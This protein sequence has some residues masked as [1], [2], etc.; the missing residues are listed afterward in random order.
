MKKL[1]VTRNFFS[2]FRWK[3]L[4]G[5]M[6]LVTIPGLV[7]G[8]FAYDVFK[9]ENFRKVE[10]SMQ[11]IAKD[12]REISRVYLQQ[13]NRVLKREEFLVEKRL[14]ALVDF[15]RD[16][17]FR[18]STS[19]TKQEVISSF[20]RWEKDQHL[21]RSGHLMLLDSAGRILVSNRAA[22][23]N[24]SFYDHLAKD[25]QAS[26]QSFLTKNLK[27]RDRD[28]VILHFRISEN[29]NQDVPVLGAFLYLPQVDLVLC[30]YSLYAD[31]KSYELKN[32]LQDE[33]KYK[34]GE[35]RISENGYIFVI[36]S[37]GDYVVSKGR[38]RDGENLLETRDLR[39][40]FLIKEIIERARSLEGDETF[41]MS[42]PWQNFGEKNTS[43]KIIVASYFPQWDWIIGVSSYYVDVYKGLDDI[44]RNIIII[45]TL[46]ILIGGFIAYFFALLLSRPILSL[47]R[48]A[49][50]AASGNLEVQVRE[51]ITKRDDELG[52]LARSFSAMINEL[53]NKIQELFAINGNLI[54][55]IEK[56]EKAEVEI[57]EL[58]NQ[59]ALIS[60]EAGMY[61]VA[62]GVLHN[63]GNVL[64]SIN[65]STQVLKSKVESLETNSYSR[66]MSLMQERNP[67]FFMNDEKGKIIPVYIQKL[68]EDLELR[69][70]EILKEIL[71]LKKSVDHVNSVIHMQQAYC[72]IRSVIEPL[73]ISEVVEMSIAMNADILE[74]YK[75]E[76]T[77]IGASII[78]QTDKHKMLQVLV[79]L[80][81]NAVQAINA[82][83]PQIRKLVISWKIEV[84]GYLYLEV[85]DTGC[86]IEP[87]NLSKIFTHGFTTK[88]EGNGL[89]LHMSLLAMKELGGDMRVFSDGVGQGTTLAILLPPGKA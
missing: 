1:A 63:V 2:G 60:R 86:G 71:D 83:N 59:L 13:N 15:T 87:E 52:D 76:V 70:N 7:T 61:E 3:L 27:N 33:L 28:S 50:I 23:K 65:T 5:S 45:T 81:R 75:I 10:Q 74:K 25:Q 55:E 54:R 34:I 17:L 51:N 22:W 68:R 66:L 49:E 58:G 40:H 18:G 14:Q 79:N 41:T 39:G 20:N 32:I 89:G 69:K 64:N 47:K 73:Q 24:T 77:V 57:K 84:E 85:T 31:Y 9:R 16:I 62:S 67:E 46:S 38:M 26:I 35:Q 44:R 4:L 6:L 43:D 29:D 42:Y 48:V 21:G 78:F 37:K 72:K 53:K 8:W 88:K 19:S 36:N 56:R 12:W 30:A 80:I 82:Q 11:I